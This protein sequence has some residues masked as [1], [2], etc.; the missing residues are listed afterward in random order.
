M[1]PDRSGHHRKRQACLRP[2]SPS[3]MT[4]Q[5]Q[6]HGCHSAGR[7]RCRGYPS[8]SALLTQPFDA[9][10]DGRGVRCLRG[11]HFRGPRWPCSARCCR[12]RG[13]QDLV[14][15]FVDGVGE[16]V[17]LDGGKDEGPVE[18]GVDLVF[19]GF[20]ADA[21]LAQPHPVQTQPGLLNRLARAFH[22]PLILGSGPAKAPFL[23]KASWGGGSGEPR[24]GAG[25]QGSIAPAY[26]WSRPLVMSR[27]SWCRGS[28][29]L[30]DVVMS[31][32][33]A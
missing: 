2:E 30:P 17:S 7:G 4:S 20:S 9:G 16:Q 5:I 33:K 32:A 18:V 25:G 6:R 3:S 8:H 22:W 31:V 15:Q 12:G 28:F 24:P 27:D 29:R 13:A 10:K 11:T 23:S 1:L 21:E 19:A 26:T 14:D